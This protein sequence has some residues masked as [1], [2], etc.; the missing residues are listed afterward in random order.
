MSFVI[1]LLRYLIL[2]F[3]HFWRHVRLCK[4]CKTVL[5]VKYFSKSSR[6]RRLFFTY[7]NV[8]VNRRHNNSTIRVHIGSSSDPM[9]SHALG[10]LA[11]IG[12][13]R[14]LCMQQREAG[15]HGRHIESVTSY[16]SS[17]IQLQQSMHIYLKNNP[18]KFHPDPIS[19]AFWTNSS[20]LTYHFCRVV[21]IYKPR[22]FWILIWNLVQQKWEWVTWVGGRRRRK[23]SWSG[24]ARVKCLLALIYWWTTCEVIVIAVIV[25]VVL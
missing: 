14:T 3:R 11:G 8:L 1:I 17:M 7:F 20:Q 5:W 22:T 9:T 18:A 15:S 25:K 21:Q 12:N 10:E 24:F 19:T 13:R 6:H 23:M 16:R 4:V 2:I